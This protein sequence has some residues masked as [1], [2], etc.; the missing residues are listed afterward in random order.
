MAA[1]KRKRTRR[2]ST[3]PATFPYFEIY[4]D[5]A[6]EWRWRIQARNGQT[7]ADSGEGYVTHA[8]A[9]DAVH[10]LNVEANWPIRVEEVPPAPATGAPAPSRALLSRE[11]DKLLAALTR[12]KVVNTVPLAV[13]ADTVVLQDVNTLRALLGVGEVA[14]SVND[15]SNLRALLGVPSVVSLQAYLENLRALLG[16]PEAIRLANMISGPLATP[17]ERLRGLL[18]ALF[19]P[20]V[21]PAGRLLAL[22]SDPRSTPQQALVTVLSD[23]RIT[24][25]DRVRVLLSDPRIIPGSLVELLVDPR[26]P[27]PQGAI[28]G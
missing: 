3:A 2:P 17:E 7:I 15:V 13:A 10:R 27:S 20:E 14:I 26:Q 23:P 12:S 19:G 4:A 1:K 28:R 18:A 11:L 24:P 6:G 22:L 5:G 16:S 8:N 9:V 25:A 21:T